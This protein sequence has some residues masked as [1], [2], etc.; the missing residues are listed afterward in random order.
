MIHSVMLMEE[1]RLIPKTFNTI[2]LYSKEFGNRSS[3]IDVLKFFREYKTATEVCNGLEKIGFKIGEPLTM[4]EL[5]TN[6]VGKITYFIFP[7]DGDIHV[8]VF[9]LE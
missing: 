3:E 1:N 9:N 2:H 5:I 7:L 6:Q 8:H 4:Q